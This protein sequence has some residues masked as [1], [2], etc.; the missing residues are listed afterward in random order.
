MGKFEDKHELIKLDYYDGLD[1]A[2]IAR[3]YGMSRSGVRYILQ[4]QGVHKVA[5]RRETTPYKPE[6]KGFIMKLWPTH[7][8]SEILEEARRIGYSLNLTPNA[9]VKAVQRWEGRRA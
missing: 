5:P 2:A 1:V 9:I 7:S 8:A 6:I 3:K 4:S